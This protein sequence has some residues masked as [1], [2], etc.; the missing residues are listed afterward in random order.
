M[1]TRST[2]PEKA[3]KKLDNPQPDALRF[4]R[5]DNDHPMP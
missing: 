3:Q 2:E 4:P 1:A 5:Y